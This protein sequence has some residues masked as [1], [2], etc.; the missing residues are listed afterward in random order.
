MRGLVPLSSLVC[1]VKLLGWGVENGEK[2]WLAANSWNTNWGN[3]GFFK[4][5][6]GQN[7]CMIED[8]VFAGQVR[9]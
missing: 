4:I 1:V 7:E 2:Y 6:K 8:M 9:A 5:A 3:G